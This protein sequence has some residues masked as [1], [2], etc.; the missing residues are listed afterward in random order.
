MVDLRIGSFNVENLFGRAKVFTQSPSLDVGDTL[1]GLIDEFRKLIEQKNYTT[2]R[3]QRM[4]ELYNDKKLRDFILIR[5]DRRKLWQRAGWAI[6]GVAAD[7]AGDWDGGIEFKLAPWNDLARSNTAKVIKATKADILCVVE[8]ENRPSLKAFDTHLLNSRYKY[9]MLIDGNDQRGID[10]GLFSKY[11]IG[12]V[13]THIFDKVGGKQVFSRDC[14]EVEVRG[15]DDEPIY[16]LLNHFK[17]KGYDDGTAD[18]KRKRQATQVNK[19]LDKYKLTKQ[20][21]VV[22]GD[23]NDTPD[24]DPLK[25]LLETYALYDVLEEGFGDAMSKRWTYHYQSFEQIDYLLVSRP[26]RNALEGA[27]VI[28]RGI[29]NLEQLTGTPNSGVATETEYDT[30][31]HWTNQASDHGAVWAKLNL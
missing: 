28:R 6:V 4:L 22:A 13:W 30:V 5:E 17:S 10:V 25:P 9:E 8:A 26:L 7:G 19:L 12:G 21:V 11:P 27:G 2:L 15:P 31:T 16:V 23:L 24:S 14:L 3:K 1:L 18:S 20:R 29:Y